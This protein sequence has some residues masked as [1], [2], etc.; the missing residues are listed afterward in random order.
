MKAYSDGY[1]ALPLADKAMYTAR[2]NAL[3]TLAVED[4]TED[5]RCAAVIKN[6]KSLHRTVSL[7][8]YIKCAN[9]YN[10]LP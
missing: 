3:K 7:P 6:T 8:T 10:C 5:E 9:L 4:M 2:S 1:A